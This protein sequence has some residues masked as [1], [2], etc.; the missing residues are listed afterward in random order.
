MTGPDS[1][2]ERAEPRPA[3]DPAPD[4]APGP[5]SPGKK[6][7]LAILIA[8]S[9]IGP[10]A[11]NIFVPSMPG[12]QTTFGISYAT[13]QLTLTL[14]LIGTA[15]CQLVYGPLSDRFGRR[16]VMIVGQGL[17]V[18]ASLAAAL[19]PTIDILIAARTLQ[20]VGGAAGIVISRAIVRDLY[21]REKSASVL[22]Y[23]TAAWVLAPMIAPTLG[24]FLDGVGG[25]AASFF[26][27]TGVGALVWLAALALLHETHHTREPVPMLSA[28]LVGFAQLLRTPKFL[29][30]TMTM[31]FGSGV[32]FSFL[33]GAPYIMVVVLERSP[34][35]YGLWFIIV[36]A[37]YMG[38]NILAGRYSERAGVDRMVGIGAALSLVGTGACLLLI[39]AGVISPVAIFVPMILVAFGNGMGL[40]NGIAG[41]MSISPALAGTAAGLAGFMQM[42]L[43]AALSQSVGVL[44]NFSPW[45]SLYVMVVSAALSLLAY[46]WI[47]A[48]GPGP[49]EERA[50]GQHPRP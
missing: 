43:G 48:S 33:A 24:G 12:L 9:A 32:F 40:P 8:L 31:A 22:G 13:A 41:A 42:G 39:L 34:L 4:P 2:S 21:G 50:P 11:L 17:F 14:Y 6:P 29:A 18:A 38:G 19:A 1:A 28:M 26:F 37:G 46:R 20:A 16:P 35:E 5:A 47:V 44:Q 36:S 3:P 7:S 30:Y 27:L 49:G 15:T 23:I 10:L 25:W 45:A